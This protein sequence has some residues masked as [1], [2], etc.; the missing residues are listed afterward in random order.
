M[1]YK[2]YYNLTDAQWD[3]LQK[4]S[5]ISKMDCWFYLNHDELGDFIQ[6]AEDHMKPMNFC[7][8]IGQLFDG[9]T[10][11]DWEQLTDEDH[12][13]LKELSVDLLGEEITEF[14]YWEA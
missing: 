12:D 8:G 6:D 5:S 14:T 13:A 11:R 4:L 2:E 1:V 9:M 7:D 3:A 10:E